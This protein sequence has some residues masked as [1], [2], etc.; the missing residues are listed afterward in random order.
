MIQLGECMFGEW[1]SMNWERASEF[2]NHHVDKYLMRRVKNE[3]SCIPPGGGVVSTLKWPIKDE[4]DL[5]YGR[6]R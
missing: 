4:M 3:L 2:R 5:R 1:W 6:V